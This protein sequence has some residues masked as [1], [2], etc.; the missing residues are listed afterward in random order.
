M[1]RSCC[2]DCCLFFFAIFFPPIAVL[3]E[4][5]CGADFCLNLLLTLLGFLPGTIHALWACF[6]RQSEYQGFQNQIIV[7]HADVYEDRRPYA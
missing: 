3:M 2:M 1:A 6:C 4:F 7:T 5:G